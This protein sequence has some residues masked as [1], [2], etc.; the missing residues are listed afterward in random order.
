MFFT[1]LL[2]VFINS[3][4]A[5]DDDDCSPSEIANDLK[6]KGI[7]V[8]ESHQMVS[9][10]LDE[11][12]KLDLMKNANALMKKAKVFVA[13]ISDEYVQDQTCRMEFQFAKSTLKKPVVPLV[14]GSGREWQLSV[15]GKYVKATNL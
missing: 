4:R 11:S 3:S 8:V 1:F 12:E 6:T 2:S 9:R 5:D 15:V 10:S 7:N 14:F 13:C